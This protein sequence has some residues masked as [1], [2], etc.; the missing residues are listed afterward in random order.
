MDITFLKNIQYGK[1]ERHILDLYI[2]QAPVTN[3]G[4]ILIIHGG[5]WTAGD[6]TAHTQDATYW[7]EK[8][9][10]CATMNYRYVDEHTDIFDELDD[11]TSALKKIKS[12]CSEH[13]FDLKRL[14]LFGGSAGAHL[15]LMYA[16]TRAEQAPVTPVAVFCHCPPTICNTKEF[17]YGK[18]GEFEDWKYGVLSFCCG[19]PVSK[20]TINN[21]D[22]QER[23]CRMS[24]I[25]HVSP[26]SVP[27]G[28]CH[29]IKDEIVPYEH[30]LMFLNTLEK[31]GVTNDLLTYPKS[32]HAM[33]EDPETDIKAKALMEQYLKNY[34][35]CS[36]ESSLSV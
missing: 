36:P 24:P 7:S 17:L 5:G 19:V 32:G 9:Y 22:V 28:I 4:L 21:E 1:N 13:G 33:N 6:K 18:N 23:L 14:L 29:G 2:P 12:V 11:I 34:L 31:N 25:F 30:T 20:E 3:S 27:T 10:I 26:D 8:G 35:F 15:S 16:Y